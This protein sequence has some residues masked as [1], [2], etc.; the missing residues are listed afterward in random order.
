MATT[1]P[2]T[3]LRQLYEEAAQEYFDNL[4]PEH[5]MEAVPHS[6]QK[7]ITLASLALVT[8]RRPDIQVFSELLVQ[9][10]VGDR[11]YPGQVV[12]DNMIVIYHEPIKARGSY[13][14]VVTQ[15]VGP[16]CVLEYVSKSNK[17][18]DYVDNMLKYETELKVPYY[19]LFDSDK[20]DLRLYRHNKRKYVKVRANESGRLAIPELD[21]EAALLEEWVRF[22]FQ[23]KLLPLPA[24]LQ[25]DLDQTQHE[26]DETR[27]RLSNA[28]KQLEDSRR[29]QLALEQELALLRA[30][31]TEPQ[32]PRVDDL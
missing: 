6:K 12:P 3:E 32:N 8:F 24:D 16:Y 13:D 26:L 9:Y 4:P 2:L 29:V 23:G 20:Q 11:E 22:W 21:L 30:Q 28:N 19:L 15:P 25:R 31:R 14:Y 10:P 17:R 1:K 18:K 5:F 7:E 27:K